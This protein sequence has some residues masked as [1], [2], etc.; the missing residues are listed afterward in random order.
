MFRTVIH[1]ACLAAALATL[2]ACAT[3][4]L[5][6]GAFCGDL[7]KKPGSESETVHGSLWGFDWS[8]RTVEKCED[9]CGI[10]RVEVHTNAVFVLASVV[11]L[12]LYVPQTVEWWCQAEARNDED[13]EVFVPDAQDSDRNE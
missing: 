8:Q 11:S 10:Y 9:D 13:E 4:E 1:G 3:F 7:E 2:S 5:E 12:G 6:T